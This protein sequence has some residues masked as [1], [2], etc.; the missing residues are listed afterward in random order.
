MKLLIRQ[1]RVIDTSSKWHGKTVDIYLEDGKIHEI[2]EK[3]NRSCELE[4]QENNLHISKGW[5]DLKVHFADPGEEHKSTIQGGLDAA[6]F[7]GFTHVAVL[8]STKPVLDNKTSVEYVLRRGENAVTTIHPMGCITKKN[9]G[10]ALAEMYDMFQSGVRLFSDDLVPVNGG[11]MYRA[12]LYSK[13]FDGIVVGFA[14]DKSISGGGMVNEGEASTKTGLK[15][16]PSISEVIELERNLRLLEYTG[17]NLHATGIANAE[18]VDLIRKAKAKGLNITADVHAQHL[19]YNETAVLDFDVNFKLMPPLR[20]EADRIALWEGLKD[21]TIDCI[22][23]DHRPNDTEETDLEFDHAN[24]GNSTLQTLFG[25][26]GACPEF[27]L[28]LVVKALTGKGRELLS[29]D[30][31]SIE[32]QSVADLSLFIPEKPWV[33]THDD[34]VIPCTNTP[35]LNKQLNGFVYGVINNGKFALKETR[36]NV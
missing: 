5:V 13:N 20:R 36:E 26:L 24:Y 4:I 14:H 28:E 10:E 3:I 21:G 16:D 19:I 17:G 7:G 8:P 31:K 22:V 35:A 2:A 30:I 11:I 12:L 32:D 27:D 29:L 25:E 15:A 33:F 23:S 18:S 9:Q 34:L 6:S 1:V